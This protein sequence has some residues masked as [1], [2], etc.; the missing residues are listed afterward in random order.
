MGLASQ[1]CHTPWAILGKALP[2][3]G[4]NDFSYPMG[5]EEE[6]YG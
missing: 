1:R 3:S 6:W 2:L 5:E 4:L